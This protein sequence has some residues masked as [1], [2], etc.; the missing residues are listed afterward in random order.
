MT[1]KQHIF[2]GVGDPYTAG[3]P[4]TG[5]CHHYL[6]ESTGDIWQLGM[7]GEWV[8]IYA[9]GSVGLVAAYDEGAMGGPPAEPEGPY[10]SMTMDGRLILNISGTDLEI[11]LVN[12]GA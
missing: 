5:E 2:K 11:Q 8:L 7:N 9:G 3:A 12:T 10:L 1:T 4:H 6:D